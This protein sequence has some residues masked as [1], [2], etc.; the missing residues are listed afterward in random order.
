MSDN[1]K[2]YFIETGDPEPLPIFVTKQR[3]ER[4]K[5]QQAVNFA[6]ASVGLEGFEL[7]NVG[8]EHAR[9]YVEGDFTLEEFIE[10]CTAS[11]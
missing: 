8:E 3:D 9:S 4:E 5:R 2:P 7:S 1:D 6:R 11:T 10:R